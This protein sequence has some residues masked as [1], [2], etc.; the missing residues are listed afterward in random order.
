MH[1]MTI[2]FSPGNLSASDQQIVSR[3]FA[4]HSR[5]ANAPMFHKERFDW[6][7]RGSDEQLVGVATADLLWDG[8]RT[9]V[10]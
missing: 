7:A 4:E 8:A 3:G 10:N 1:P 9:T 5:L 2:H 6:S